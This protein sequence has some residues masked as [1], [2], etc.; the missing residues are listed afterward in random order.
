M[1]RSIPLLLLSLWITSPLLPAAPLDGGFIH[2]GYSN[3]DEPLGGNRLEALLSE[4]KKN[5]MDT[6]VVLHSR[7]QKK[8][9]TNQFEWVGHLDQRIPELFAIA[10]RLGLQVYFGLSLRSVSPD[11]EFTAKNLPYVAK[12]TEATV[13]SVLKLVKPSE[14]AGWY[15]PEEPE[16]EELDQKFTQDYIGRLVKEVRKNSPDKP[17]LSAP[18]LNGARSARAEFAA[19]RASSA[20]REFLDK[21]GITILMLQD[22]VGADGVNAN[23]G[24][25]RPSVEEYFRAVS[26]AIGPERLWCDVELF[27]CCLTPNADWNTYAATSIARLNEQLWMTRS[28]I[29]SKRIAFLLQAHMTRIEL[30]GAKKEH[31][32]GA[33]RLLASYR[34]L[35]KI[36]GIYVKPAGYKWLTP[37]APQYADKGNMLTNMKSGDPRNFLHAGWAGVQGDLGVEFQFEAPMFL[38]WVAIHVLHDSTAAIEFP[39]HLDIECQAP[40]ETTWKK[41][42]SGDREIPDPTIPNAEYVLT[43]TGSIDRVCS[44]IRVKATAGGHWTFISEVEIVAH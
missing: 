19:D 36:D 14:I 13:K 32:L 4:F 24:Q 9:N 20:T 7:I 34:A 40:G 23:W 18:A 44:A 8:C 2:F 27:N 11:C 22:S 42:A 29:V 10:K 31:L 41:V 39:K 38:D 35:Y 30:P 33:A 15:I 26:K 25:P 17:I 21:T 1:K 3:A 37:P 5:Q 16:L 6:V 12:D 43:H 28:P